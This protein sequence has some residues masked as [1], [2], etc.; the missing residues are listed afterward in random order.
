M[1]DS[2]FDMNASLRAKFP[3]DK[4]VATRTKEELD[5][6]IASEFPNEKYQRKSARIIWRACEALDGY[7]SADEVA[8]QLAHLVDQGVYAG[9]GDLTK[10]AYSEIGPVKTDD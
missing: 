7:F 3:G 5:A 1:A 8:D 4:S 2:K 9:Y 6:F 10:W